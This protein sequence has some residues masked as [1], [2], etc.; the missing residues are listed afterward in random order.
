M[1]GDPADPRWEEIVGV[2]NNLQF[3]ASFEKPDT[4][5]QAYRPM[6]QMT[7][8]WLNVMLRLE[9]AVELAAVA[10]PRVVAE[11]VTVRQRLDR[12]LANPTLL[13]RMLGGFAGLGLVLTVLGVVGVIAYSVEQRTTEFGI[14][15]A[16]GAQRRDVLWLVLNKGLRLS[17]LGAMVGLMGAWA[18]SRWLSAAVP[19]LPTHDPMV[20]V[21]VTAVLVG[22]ALL[23]CYLPAR[24]AT[25][26]DPIEALRAE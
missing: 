26:V 17:L 23:A 22:V 13:G 14:R 5:L 8:R 21:V 19:T 18:V 24:R 7:H 1:S 3:P 11:I 20:F 10:L 9:G 2:V 12:H 15:L 6:G 16:L 25:R 4:T